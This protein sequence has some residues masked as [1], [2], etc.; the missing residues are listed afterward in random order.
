M[1]R[2]TPF[3]SSFW[4]SISC[5]KIQW[6]SL[7]YVV[8][9]KC[10]KAQSPFGLFLILI[11]TRVWIMTSW[12]FCIFLVNFVHATNWNMHQFSF[13]AHM[14]F[15]IWRENTQAIRWHFLVFV[16][17]PPPPLLPSATLLF[18]LFARFGL[19]IRIGFGQ[20][21]LLFGIFIA[22]VSIHFVV[23]RCVDRMHTTQT[24]CPLILQTMQAHFEL[25]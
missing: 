21:F 15:K 9:M 5:I 23:Y 8:H 4:S 12:V 1:D 13:Y 16:K 24:T 6:V 2:K 11:W 19:S 7:I 14:K 17:P 18:V 10:S 20:A 22:L 3:L 25:I